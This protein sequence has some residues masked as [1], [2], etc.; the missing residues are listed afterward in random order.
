MA[1]LVFL[2]L[3][4]PGMVPNQR[5]LSIVVSDWESYLGSLFSTLGWWDHVF[6]L[7][8][9]SPTELCVSYSI[10]YFF[11]VIN[12]RKVYAYH[13]APWC[14]PSID[15]RDRRSHLNWTKQRAWEEMASWSLEEVKK[16]ISW[17]LEE[18][19]ARHKSLPGKQ[20]E[21]AKEQQRRHRGSRP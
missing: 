1:I 18:V 6:V 7:L 9:S 16:R 3:C 14:T 21:A 20:A 19:L 17:T 5:Q 10:R 12:K 11:S 8:L 2:F 15:E 13:A 4:W